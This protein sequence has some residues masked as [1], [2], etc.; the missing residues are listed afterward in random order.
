SGYIIVRGS[1]NSAIIDGSGPGTTS[2]NLMNIPGRNSGFNVLAGNTMR[3]IGPN[4]DISSHSFDLDPGATYVAEITGPSHSTFKT[5]DPARA[6]GI[7]KVEFTGYTPTVGDSWTLIDAP[8]FAS[9]FSEIQVPDLDL[10]VGQGFYLKT[11]P[12]AGSVYGETAKLVLEK[13]LV[14]KVNRDTRE[15]SI[16]TGQLPV[17][18]DGYSVTS[19]LG[20]LNPANWES[21]DSRNISDWRESPQNGSH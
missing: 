11:G 4:A 6:D 10:P 15:M 2:V 12:D 16:V 21:L 20:G 17:A 19:G 8:S 9:T 18:I 14:L 7:L 13:Q 3:I 5:P 1:G